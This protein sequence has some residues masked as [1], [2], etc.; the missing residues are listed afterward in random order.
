MKTK[1]TNHHMKMSIGTETPLESPPMMRK[2]FQNLLW[3]TVT[4]S[5]QEPSSLT[6]RASHSVSTQKMSTYSPQITKTM[7]PA[8]ILIQFDGNLLPENDDSNWIFL[9]L[10]R[11]LTLLDASTFW[12]M[13]RTLT[14]C[15]QCRSNWVKR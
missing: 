10:A 3:P 6:T 8:T 2:R 5:I 14:S 1:R 7:T 11:S 15:K 13:T 9:A 4:Y 12:T